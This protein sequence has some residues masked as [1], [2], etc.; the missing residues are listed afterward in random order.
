MAPV[1]FSSGSTRRLDRGLNLPLVGYTWTRDIQLREVT[2]S[3]AAYSWTNTS[4]GVVL[5][6][7]EW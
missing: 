6:L 1:P 7:I 3:Q 2:L 4:F 5:A